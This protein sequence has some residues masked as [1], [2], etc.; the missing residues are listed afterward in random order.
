MTD[1]SNHLNGPKPKAVLQTSINR[2][3]GDPGPLNF[4]MIERAI[5]EGIPEDDQLDWKR[6]LPSDGTEFAKDVAAFANSRGG[7]I[8]YGVSE[9]RKTSRA[10]SAALVDI[11]E[12]SQRRLRSWVGTRVSPLLGT[13]SLTPLPAPGDPS[14]GFLVVWVG[15]SP[16]APHM[17]GNDERLGCPYRL[18]AQTVWMREW[19][20]SRAY[21][22]RFARR[23]TDPESAD[24][25]GVSGW[26]MLL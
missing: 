7:V 26:R 12:A 5:A 8:V 6:D 11:S 25:V 21:Q 18:H 10:Q 20:I 24:S 3:L 15:E 23:V 14:T 22:E 9:D 1:I 2:Q 4:S 19:D 16:D 13:F 17:I